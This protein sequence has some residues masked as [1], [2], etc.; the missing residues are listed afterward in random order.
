MML[1]DA[2]KQ[3][4]IKVGQTIRVK[5]VDYHYTWSGKVTN[6][7][8]DTVFYAA[9]KALHSSCVDQGRGCFNTSVSKY[10]V[11]RINGR[12]A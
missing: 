9:I 12:F 7:D 8:H 3:G 4:K 10:K 1:D 5:S 2:L 6:L 11:L